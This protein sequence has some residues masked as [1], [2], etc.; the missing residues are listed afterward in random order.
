MF[1]NYMLGA[2]LALVAAGSTLWTPPAT[3]RQVELH[4][5]FLYTISI[6]NG[7]DLESRHTYISC[8]EGTWE[9]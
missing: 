9:V 5:C 4:N 3:A 7:G 8:D 1:K 2:A 6:Y